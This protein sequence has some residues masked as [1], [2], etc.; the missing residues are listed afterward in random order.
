MSNIRRILL[1]A[2]ASS[3]A[4]RAAEYL[5]R[6]AT[7]LG[8]SETI[9]LHVVEPETFAER[10]TGGRE[11]SIELAELGTN[12]TRSIQRI[13]DAAGVAYHLD[14]KLGKPADVITEVV[15]SARVDEV[16][17]G[18][19]GMNPWQGL[20][21]GSV[22]YNVIHQVSVPITTVGTPEPGGALPLTTP[23]GLHRLLLAT[24][25]SE[26]AARAAEYV[27]NMQRA[28]VPLEVH[29]LNVVLPIPM[30]YIGGSLSQAVID[31]HYQETGTSALHGARA[32]LASTA[33]KFTEHIVTGHAADRIVQIA[34]ERE[35][36]RIIMGTRGLGAAAEMVLGSVTY[37]VVHLSPLPVTLVK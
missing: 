22:A 5:A 28:G 30:G 15:A 23:G 35:C 2:D 9:L 29:L 19:R 13:L 12:A 1:A 7:A 24:D 17:I 6:Y 36:T 18:T 37:R 25:G 34:K 20:L 27:A 14:I 32:T 31:S 4:E 33:I 16:V 10:A 21:V 26:H 11:T 8:R 3:H